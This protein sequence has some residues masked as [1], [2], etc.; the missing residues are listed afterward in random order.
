MQLINSRRKKLMGI[1]FLAFTVFALGGYSVLNASAD[2]GTILFNAASF[3][4]MNTTGLLVNLDSASEY[5]PSPWQVNVQP[6]VEW[7]ASSTSVLISFYSWTAGTP[8]NDNVQYGTNGP[9]CT[10]TCTWSEVSVLVTEGGA[11]VVY[12]SSSSSA[13]L[14]ELFTGTIGAGSSSAIV[15]QDQVVLQYTGDNTTG[16]TL[17]AYVEDVNGNILSSL[18]NV[19]LNLGD[20]NYVGANSPTNGL[21]NGAQD[22]LVNGYVLVTMGDLSGG[23]AANFDITPIVDLVIAIVP[24]IVVVALVKWLSTWFNGFKF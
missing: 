22:P 11:A 23:T 10:G 14:T 16:G 21:A 7:N 15:E 2:G 20:L 1:A 12:Y 18:G 24:L 3:H 9:A 13:T 17:Y 5:Q 4:Y 8:T 19:T 6:N